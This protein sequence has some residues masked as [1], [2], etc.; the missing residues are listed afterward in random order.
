MLADCL[1]VPAIRLQLELTARAD[2]AERERIVAR[3]A[4][5][6]HAPAPP[7]RAPVLDF[8]SR[9]AGERDDE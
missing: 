3:A 1:A 5:R 8:K 6:R 4:S 2:M 7:R 9:A